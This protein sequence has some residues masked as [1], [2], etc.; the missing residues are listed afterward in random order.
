VDLDRA[1]ADPEIV[2]DQLVRSPG[3]LPVK[4][5]PF[6]RTESCD[7]PDGVGDIEIGFPAQRRL[8]RP[9]Q[10]FIALL[11]FNEIG[12][13]RLHRANGRLDVSLACHYN[14]CEIAPHLEKLRLDLKP[15]MP[16]R[17]TSNRTQPVLN[18]FAAVRKTLGWSK[19]IGLKFAELSRRSS[20]RSTASSSSRT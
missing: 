13:A 17:R 20:E 10:S 19:V 15:L 11:L 18:V 6:P 3:Q 8:N 14:N 12:C 5:F 7:A 2:G 4:N 9:K 1:H 16:G